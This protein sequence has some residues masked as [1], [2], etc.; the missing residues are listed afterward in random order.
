MVKDIEKFE[1]MLLYILLELQEVL[2]D[3]IAKEGVSVH[4]CKDGE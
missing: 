2:V 4:V 1:V 3:V